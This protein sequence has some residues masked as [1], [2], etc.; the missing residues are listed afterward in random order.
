MEFSVLGPLEV[1]V[2]G[3][4]VALG[5][6]KPRALLAV[7]A[8]H[9]NQ[10]VSTEH[11][12]LA[13][14]GDDAP[15]RAVKTVQVHVSR[16]RRALGDPDLL[17]TTSAGYRLR[18][19]P[20]ELDADRFED[21]VREGRRAL[22]AG[23]PEQAA[24]ALREAL[25]LWR[26]PPLAE[27]AALPFAPPEI[28]RLEEQR[29]IALEL[30]LDADLAAGRHAELVG[31]LQRLTSL[32]PWRERLHAQLILA[33]YRAGRQADALA[34]Y[35]DARAALIDQLGVEP[36]PE[37]R[38]LEAA[39][40]RHDRAVQA[41]GRSEPTGPPRPSRLPASL[42]RTVGRDRDVHAVVERFRRDDVR[43][44]TL[45]GPGG[46][47]KTRLSLDVARVLEPDF[48]H[49][50]WFVS[51]AGTAQPAH[52]AAT[53]AQ[54]LAITP[55]GGEAPGDAVRRYLADKEALLVLDNFE[56]LL[57]AAPM[58]TD[59][60][61]ASPALA[62]LTT[63]REPLRIDAEHCF[64]VTPLAVPVHGGRA[65]VERTAASA[66]FVERWR[67]HDAAFAVT[68]AN[69]H[70]IATI[71]RR[72]EGLPLAIELAA[73]RAPLLDPRE[74]SARLERSL[75]AL[76]RA[77]RDAPA[78]HRTLRAAID[79]SHRLLAPAEAKA[80]AR[81]AV[82]AG[83]ATVEAAEHV[84]GGDLDALEGLVDKQLLQRH[85][86]GHGEARLAMLET[87]REYARERLDRGDDAAAIHRRHCEEFLAL[88]EVAEP[89]LSTAAEAE[90]LP[91]LDTEL[92]NLR[93]ALDWSLRHD[94]VLGLRLAGLLAE[95]WDLRGLSSEGLEWLR[96]ALEAVG[97]DAPIRDR[98]RAHR[99]HVKLLEEQGSIH[100]A[101]GLRTDARARALEAL[102]LSRQAG[103]PSGIADALL[104]LGHL[105]TREGFPNEERRALAEEALTHARQ[106][107]DERL[108][109]DALKD[110]A[111]ALAP[112]QGTA[113]LEQAVAALG[114]IGAT[115]TLAMLYN[116]SAYNAIKA[117]S[118]DRARLFLERA[119]SLARELADES[120]LSSL[121]GN[122]GLAAL[123]S[124]DLAA[125][126][127]AFEAQLR[128][129]GEL[130][131]PWLASEGLAGLSAIATRDGDLERAARLLGAATAHGPIGDADVVS[132]LERDFFA[133]A[134]ARHGDR[135]WRQA[136]A[137]GAQLRFTEAIQLGLDP[138][139]RR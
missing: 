34:A 36:S 91:R 40:L 19:R 54:A 132:Q 98:A 3:R 120:L 77:P 49:A 37:L 51:L 103:D 93:A 133:P 26:G 22:A 85:Q 33:L 131:V 73:A 110:R 107:G 116:T 134:Q 57:S 5:G 117:G 121:Y 95:F 88:A 24:V 66:L 72:L 79:W 102:A 109:A 23:R 56:H 84:T 39:I 7:L 138:A 48:E 21:H 35:R 119:E 92:D 127:G 15:A 61:G 28:S 32:H 12:A 74:L 64:A 123:F 76:G 139:A 45:T 42:T 96:R 115:R 30:R 135:Q 25:S 46:V 55:V 114:R 14:W 2:D 38:H 50:A 118:Y 108:V 8:L 97:E 101:G 69:A 20:G 136:H 122:A 100:D 60:L 43:L 111:L 82:F 67:R 10:P 13:L 27:L 52:M 65:E 44:V 41:P 83:G 75:D 53:V 89:A 68:D 112:D 31:E 87:V 16:L 1:R 62:V 80:F 29:L 63:S 18:V 106:A 86:T 6:L 113:E 128:L 9:A 47:G 78:R 129:C 58:V 126:R 94:A 137:A 130:V 59:L 81:F 90:W 99:G 17:A 70:A 124:G 71:C 104:L 4:A 105:A 11:L 125:A